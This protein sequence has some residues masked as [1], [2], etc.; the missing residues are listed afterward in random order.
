ML[1]VI[2]SVILEIVTLFRFIL[3]SSMVRIQGLVMVRF[4]FRAMT[5]FLKVR[6]FWIVSVLVVPLV[7]FVM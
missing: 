1:L 2:I 3:V 5:L 4:P 6:S 7:V